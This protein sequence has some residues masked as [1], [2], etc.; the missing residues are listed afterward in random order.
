MASQRIPSIYTTSVDSTEAYNQ[1]SC[2][3]VPAAGINAA[4]EWNKHM[5]NY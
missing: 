4:T 3:A 5:P 1:K 2:A